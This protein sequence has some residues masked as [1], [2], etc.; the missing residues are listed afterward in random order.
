MITETH[1]KCKGEAEEDEYEQDGEP[2][3]LHGAP[4][5]HANHDAEESEDGQVLDSFDVDDESEER[6]QLPIKQKQK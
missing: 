6:Q 3:D 5:D 4:F 2:G 1:E